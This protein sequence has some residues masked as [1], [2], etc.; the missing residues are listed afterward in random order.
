MDPGPADLCGQGLSGHAGRVML[1][2]FVAAGWTAGVLALAACP[3]FAE[4]PAPPPPDASTQP[5][6]EVKPVTV[7]AQ[8]MDAIK[9]FV[10]QVSAAPQQKQ[11]ARWDR[12]ICSGVLGLPEQHAQYLN[13]RLAANAIGV[14]LQTGKPGCKPNVLIFVA[15]DA[16]TF[17]AE[18]VKKH[19][20]AFGAAGAANTRGRK[21]LAEFT[22]RPRPVRWWHLSETAG[23]D[24]ARLGESV[25]NGGGKGSRMTL[26]V[27]NASRIHPNTQEVFANVIIVVDAKR[28]VGVSYQAL[29][30]YI[31]MVALA[32]IDPHA[33]ATDLPSILNLF[34]DRDAG[35]VLPTGLTDWDHSYLKALY[36][37]RAD[38][39]S[40]KKEQDEITDEMKKAAAKPPK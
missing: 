36:A 16:D 6:T 20:G 31:S 38:V 13:D 1:R 24:G 19:A 40:D 2:Q 10:A 23:A 27:Y 7:T 28:A 25:D 4:P 22:L 33:D 12:T 30:D 39:R 14:G 11:M 5:P 34:K 21:A 26:Q 9:S 8:R 18:I 37:V 17:V 35:A 3:A 32:Q 29:C 15:P